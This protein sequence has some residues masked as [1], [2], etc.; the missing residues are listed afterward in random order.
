MVNERISA[1]DLVFSVGGTILGG[2]EDLNFSVTADNEEAY[3]A[4]NYFPVDIVDGKKHIAGTINRA[5]IDNE[6]L[7]SLFPPDT[8][9]WPLFT[10]TGTVTSG[11]SPGRN[12]SINDAKF[13]SFDVNSL[14]LE[15]HAKNAMPF[16]ALNWKLEE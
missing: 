1:K 6:T 7:N 12:F 10:I 2:A 3:E 13:D 9:L 16:K 14:A 15:G 11:K 5:W 4:G 8:G